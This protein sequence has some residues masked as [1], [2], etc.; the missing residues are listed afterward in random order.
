H[1]DDLVGLPGAVALKAD[2]VARQRRADEALGGIGTVLPADLKR[3]QA[4]PA[5]V[6]R[7]HL[8]T[9]LE[10]PE[11]QLASVLALA[12]VRGVKAALERVGRAPLAG[13]ERVLARLVPEVVEELH[14]AGV[15]L[16]ALRQ[17]EVTRVQDREPAGRI[18]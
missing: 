3:D 15:P 13:D 4:L 12:D 14:V 8:L 7:L 16:P 9:G 17:R 11:V 10:V 1:V 18:A 6:D 5:E 2:D